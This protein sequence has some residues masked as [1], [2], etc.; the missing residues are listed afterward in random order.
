[1]RQWT[2]RTCDS[3]V[4]RSGQGGKPSEAA[5]D[6]GALHAIGICNGN[7][8]GDKVELQALTS[9]YK[10][11][12]SVLQVLYKR[13]VSDALCQFKIEIHVLQNL[14]EVSYGCAV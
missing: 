7:K 9:A 12:A 1:M 3:V 14:I 6:C 5:G 8:A 4:M 13:F 2:G 11:F 10:C